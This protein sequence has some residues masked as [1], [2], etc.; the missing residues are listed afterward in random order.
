MDFVGHIPAA[1]DDVMA[2]EEDVGLGPNLTDLQFNT[3]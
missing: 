1:V 2:F 3:S